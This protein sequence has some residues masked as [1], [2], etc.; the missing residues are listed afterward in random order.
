MKAEEVLGW[1]DSLN[2]PKTI[3]HVDS[4]KDNFIFTDEGLK[5]IDWEY[6]GMADPLLDLAMSA[7]YSYMSFD[8]AK[9]L[10]RVYAAAPEPGKVR[11]I[12]LQA[13]GE[14]GIPGTETESINQNKKL[15]SGGEDKGLLET[16]VS[17]GALTESE[18]QKIFESHG[19]IALK[20]LAPDDAYSLVIAYMGLGGLLWAL[21]GIYKM[22][23]G[24]SFGDYTLKMYR[25]FKDSYKI[26][27]KL[28]K[29]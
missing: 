23:L 26:L 9:E 11:D 2:R 25:Y 28:E 5:M 1:I 22:A 4:V 20:G 12:K 13:D 17:A 21:W 29:F 14:S 8:K 3:A 16:S 19:G 15:Q 18:L 27:R 24:E 10:V 7:I 6:A